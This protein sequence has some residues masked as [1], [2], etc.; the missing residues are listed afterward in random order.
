[1]KARILTVIYLALL[2]TS[3][4]AKISKDYLY[5]YNVAVKYYNNRKY[6]YAEKNLKKSI[7]LN[8]NYLPAYELLFRIYFDVKEYDDALDTLDILKEKK[9]DSAK[10][11]YYYGITYYKKN[12]IESAIENLKKSIKIKEN[13]DSL[14]ALASIYL[15]KKDYE[16]AIK[17]FE[18]ALKLKPENEE[19]KEKI[20]KIYTRKFL[21]EGKK[22]FEKKDY[23][24][25]ILSFQKALKYDE[26]NYE[27]LIRLANCYL[28][29]K[30]YDRAITFA[31]RAIP[32]RKKP[33]E[34]H[35][36]L[37]VA[38][39]DKKE[40]KKAIK[41][42]KL[43]LKY[44]K[45]NPK[46]YIH[47]AEIYYEKG[48]YKKAIEYYKKSAKIKPSFK[49]YTI[50][51]NLF[52]DLQEYEKAKEYYEK[53]LDIQ[54]NKKVEEAL[55]NIKAYLHFKKAR[56]YL[57]KG[58]YE[59]AEDEYR[60]A[61]DI[62]ESPEIYTA[63]GSLLLKQNR[64]DEA[65]ESLKKALEIEKDFVPAL[66]ALARCYE[67]Q[68]KKKK[69][70]ELYKKL[71]KIKKDDPDVFIKFA[72]YYYRNGNIKKADEMYKEALKISKDKEKILNL[73]ALMYYNLAV[74]EFN[75]EKFKKAEK[76]V[77]KS[78][79]YKKDFSD[80]KYL[81]ELINE[82]KKLKNI[83]Q[84]I[85][86][87]NRLFH[88][89]KFK[90]AIE[91]FKRILRLKPELDNIKYLLAYS[92][93]YIDKYKDSIN[94]LNKIKNKRKFDIYRLYILDYLFLN[95]LWEAEKYLSKA[96]EILPDN[97]ELFNLYGMLYEKKN[98]IDRAIQSY[99][100]SIE[101][102]PE[103]IDAHINLGN[104][105]YRV[106]EYDSAL[107]EYLA[108]LKINPENDVALYNSGIIY[109][110]K[111]RLNK[112][113]EMFL[114]SEKYIKNYPPLYFNI[115]R[116]YYYLGR[117]KKS[118]EYINRAL[119][120][121]YD[122]KYLWGLARVYHKLSEKNP[123][124]KKLAIETYKKCINNK[125]EKR[126][127]V[128]ARKAIVSLLPDKKYLYKNSL[129]IDPDSKQFIAKDFSIGYS[130]KNS[131]LI[132]YKTET[133]EVIW[134][135][136]SKY[137]L[138]SNIAVIN[139]YVFF[140]LEDGN[141]YSLDR[142]TGKLLWKE[143]IYIDEVKAENNYV[144]GINKEKSII[145]CIQ[146][147]KVLWE[148]KT[149]TRN[150]SITITPENL[151]LSDRKKIEIYDIKTGKKI[152]S[153]K[154]KFTPRY[155][156]KEKDRIFSFGYKKIVC[157]KKNFQK[158]WEKNLNVK[159][160]GKPSI[161]FD[162]IFV[163]V[164]GDKIICISAIDG[165]RLWHLKAEDEITSLEVINQKLFFTDRDNRIYMADLTEG[166]I[167]WKYEIDEFPDTF[168]LLYFKAE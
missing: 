107:N 153:V 48:S 124:Y 3:L 111:N 23:N 137:P 159:I 164:K 147:N 160:K 90:K 158:I 89:R 162:K 92:Y 26:N 132:C 102:N 74:R 21:S 59:E 99:K 46:T 9:F 141:F 155:V 58:K 50:I 25:A 85:E 167:Y 63:L 87:A 151:I 154:L 66:F 34:A 24:K 11:Y 83:N 72:E 4:Q 108:V 136:P 16:N 35:Y 143:S 73:L 43:S 113:L 105:Y 110:K 150:F 30:D 56:E 117:Y 127:S 93:Y 139:N 13:Y 166:K 2:F 12:E 79:E 37:G 69:A 91:L 41:N 22:F 125:E 47:L 109:Y 149:K 115:A 112:S 131:S 120:L 98:E 82:Y 86:E 54:E 10:L 97:S 76:L 60:E 106:K 103:N 31:T 29:K 28:I 123:S 20:K 161:Y 19:L 68:N 15:S 18:K 33:F 32:N 168:S 14:F 95:K 146:E 5:Y 7:D 96:K 67:I 64:L 157:M 126:I 140:G 40:Y 44:D 27:I 138:S 78:L 114:K 39:K 144:I 119:K 55:N 53:A 77:K 122:I 145:Y 81:L 148:E 100:K 70:E 128:L 52:A 135:F 84:A 80:A 163:P 65:E 8:E 1:M 152:R 36:I 142:K 94:W 42:F 88:K 51:G 57:R 118:L 121:E 75:H 116:V 133:E 38:Y 61:L 134:K 165:S 129:S 49:I 101:L 45:K 130:S 6:Y 156:L 17:Y 62:V 104:L 71:K